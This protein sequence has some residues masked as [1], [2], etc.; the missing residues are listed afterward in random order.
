M[1]VTY[2]DSYP[3]LPLSDRDDMRKITRAF[4]LTKAKAWRHEAEYRV[5][6]QD[7]DPQCF[8]VDWIDQDTARLPATSVTGVTVGS[9]MDDPAVQQVIASAHA[10]TPPVPVYRAI[11]HRKRFQLGIKRIA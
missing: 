2:T 9:L 8:A 3:A 1:R 5:L 4:V 10:A 11:T 6:V 7:E